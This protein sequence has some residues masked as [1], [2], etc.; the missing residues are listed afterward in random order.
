[1]YRDIGT[2]RSK[3]LMKMIEFLG[4]KHH[5][6]PAP[7]LL[8]NCCGRC[9]QSVYCCGKSFVN[10]LFGDVVYELQVFVGDSPAV[11]RFSIRTFTNHCEGKMLLESNSFCWTLH[12]SCWLLGLKSDNQLNNLLIYMFYCFTIL[13]SPESVCFNTFRKGKLW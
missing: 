6:S 11:E 9:N 5:W 3:C 13:L 1:M 8:G 10:V 4:H 7:H 2:S 12:K